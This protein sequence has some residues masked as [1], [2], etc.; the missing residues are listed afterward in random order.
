MTLEDGIVGGSY[1]VEETHLPL[2]LEKRM[3]ALGMT[4]GTRVTLIHKKGSG[5]SVI[6]LRGTRFAIGRGIAANILVREEAAQA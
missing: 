2:A 5:T 3:E 6:L 1:L 4:R